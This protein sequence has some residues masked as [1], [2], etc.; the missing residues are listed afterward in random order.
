MIRN[1]I[2][3]P[4]GVRGGEGGGTQ[5]EP[6]SKR[7]EDLPRTKSGGLRAN[8]MLSLGSWGQSTLK[9][10][11]A[12]IYAHT[13]TAIHTHT[14]ISTTYKRE[15]RTLPIL[16]SE[17]SPGAS[18]KLPT[19]LSP[20]RLP[21]PFYLASLSFAIVSSDYS[22]PV[23]VVERL[24]PSRER[25]RSNCRS[26][27]D[28]SLKSTPKLQFESTSSMKIRQ[29]NIDNFANSDHFAETHR[30]ANE[31][32]FLGLPCL[33]F[34]VDIA[35]HLYPRGIWLAFRKSSGFTGGGAEA[36]IAARN[37]DFPQCA[38]ISF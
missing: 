34:A 5:G 15:M 6:R 26:C 37:C 25:E 22:P 31:Q 11:R 27:F 33:T 38:C 2:H 32:A 13:A 8:W 1:W 3:D 24:S 35:A 7:V 14:C 12:H 18:F 21:F 10:A 36:R 16:A 19:S 9:S 4:C 28:K 29:W 30:T 20:I 23:F 17:R